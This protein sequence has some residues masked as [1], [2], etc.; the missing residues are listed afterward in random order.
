MYLGP[1]PV[2]STGAEGWLPLPG[3]E[4]SGGSMSAAHP[5]PPLGRHQV[6]HMQQHH[7]FHD[8][9]TPTTQRHFP[10]PS[11]FRCPG[12]GEGPSAWQQVEE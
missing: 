9:F 10:K 2:S 5:P 4:Q 8:H 7:S 6:T 12:G 1:W 3:E 11:A